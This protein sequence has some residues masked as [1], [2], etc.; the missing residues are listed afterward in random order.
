MR[1][2]ITGNTQKDDIW[3]PVADLVGLLDRLGLSW[4]VPSPLARGL[5][6]R[7]LSEALRYQETEF[8][9]IV[10]GC[11]VVL[12]FGGDGTML[13]TAH[14]VG[15]AA[16]PI[17]GVNIGRLGFLA[18]VEVAE[19]ED[20]IGR[21]ESGDFRVEERS[22][23]SVDFSEFGDGEAS[24]ALNEVVIERGASAG[25]ITVDVEVDGRFL[26][27]YWADG[28]IIAT[29]TG[30]TA[31][32]LSLG[33]PIIAPESGVI[34]ITPIAPHTLTVRPIVLSIDSRIT[35]RVRASGPSYLI[36]V[37]GRSRTLAEQGIPLAVC[38]ADYVVRLVKLP[39]RDY[40]ETLRNKL[41]WGR[42]REGI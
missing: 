38:R 3:L 32:S 7:G 17:L 22:V 15:R 5:A 28:L 18:D 1:Y 2:A 8:E 31:Y 11:D 34:V 12:S 23:L 42:R 39:E 19:L 35:V 24:F 36:A 10:P 27:S 14:A 6:E 37:D 29:P 41:M 26:N 40:F 4:S 25:M 20:T 9:E 16:K 21:L 30:S 13:R 33:G